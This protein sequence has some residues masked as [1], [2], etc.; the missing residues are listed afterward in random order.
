[1]GP[2][3]GG[4]RVVGSAGEAFVTIGEVGRN[5]RGG[6]VYACDGSCCADTSAEVA[7]AGAARDVLP[8]VVALPLLT[9]TFR[10]VG[11]V[12]VVDSAAVDT[13][14]EEMSSSICRDTSRGADVSRSSAI[15]DD[16]CVEETSRDE[17]VGTGLG[18]AVE[19][20]FFL[21]TSFL[22]TRLPFFATVGEP[23]T[24]SLTADTTKA[25]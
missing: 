13:G 15:A 16:G 14:G 2:P 23:I 12:V 3:A 8:R 17:D 22:T 19:S 20:A 18:E 4:E 21:D 6:G 5:V 11:V 7:V 1:M 9:M 24:G 25:A 10:L